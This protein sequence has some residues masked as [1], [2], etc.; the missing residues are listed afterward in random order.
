[1]GYRHGVIK[2]PCKNCGHSRDVHNSDN[3][4]CKVH[5]LPNGERCDCPGFEHK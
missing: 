2:L 1:M 3:G 5:C 4:L